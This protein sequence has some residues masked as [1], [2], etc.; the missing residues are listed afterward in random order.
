MRISVTVD[1]TPTLH[2]ITKMEQRALPPA[3][4]V[5]T[6]Q[7]QELYE[8]AAE[9]CRQL[10]CRSEEFHRKDHPQRLRASVT[11]GRLLAAGGY[12]EAEEQHLEALRRHEEA[13]GYSDPKTRGAESKGS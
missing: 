1:M 2:G 8:E 4:E 7:A 13:L 6:S 9:L 10:L 11:L 5:L 3:F 12:K